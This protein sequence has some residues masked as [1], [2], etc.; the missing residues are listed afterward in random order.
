MDR[1]T[2]EHFVSS[3]RDALSH[4]ELVVVTRQIGLTVAESRNLRGAM[5]LGDSF[6]KVTKNTLARLAVRGTKFEGLES[7]FSGPMALA[8]SADPIS[9]AK[10]S[11]QYASTN[12]KFSIVGGALNGEILDVEG[13]KKL[14][15]LPSLDELRGKLVGVLQTPATRIATLMQAP[16][17]QLVRVLNAYATKEAA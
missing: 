2:K 4:A 7:M 11:V 5:R 17:G 1:V 16:A 14:A 6:Y 12:E 3:L 10:I 15:L 8:F 13:V 9:A